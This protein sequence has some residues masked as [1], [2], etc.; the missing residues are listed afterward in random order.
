MKKITVVAGVVA[1]WPVVCGAAYAVSYLSSQA[2]LWVYDQLTKE[3][4]PK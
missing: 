4:K 3:F 2:G 1:L